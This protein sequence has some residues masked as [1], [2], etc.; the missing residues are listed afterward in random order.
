MS[1]RDS[2]NVERLAPLFFVSAEQINYLVPSGTADGNAVVTVTNA[3]GEVSTGTV[4]IS[5]VAPSLFS[6]NSSGM[7]VVAAVA[8]RR[9][10]AGQDSY[11]PAARFDSAA[12]RFVPIPIDLGPAGDQVFLIPFG[13]GFRG[14]SGLTNVQATIGGVTAPVIF[15]GAVPGLLGADQ[16]NLRLDRSLMG[17]GE[18]DVVLIV[19]GKTANT[20]RVTIK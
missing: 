10:A 11:E 19:D 14:L 7:G 13:T 9:N 18:V 2:L 17:R 6:A 12:G 20:V 1:V 4:L 5:T 3:A 8:F 16:A 15:A